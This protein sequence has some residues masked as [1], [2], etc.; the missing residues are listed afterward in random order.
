MGGGDAYGYVSRCAADDSDSVDLGFACHR[1]SITNPK[2]QGCVNCF[3]GVM[4]SVMCT[5]CGGST[6]EQ[7]DEVRCISCGKTVRRILTGSQSFIPVS[8]MA[9]EVSAIHGAAEIYELKRAQETGAYTD[10]VLANLWALATSTVRSY[11]SGRRPRIWRELE[12]ATVNR[13]T[14]VEQRCQYTFEPRLRWERAERLA[15]S[16]SAMQRAGRVRARAKVPPRR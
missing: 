4:S 11:R 2:G 1:D 12:L 3:G 8:G 15:G 10:R 9:R 13:G 14:T 5:R 7:D 16:V 6:V